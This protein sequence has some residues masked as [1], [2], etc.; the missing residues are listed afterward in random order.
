MKRVEVL[1][2]STYVHI[3]SQNSKCFDITLQAKH[4][5][6]H[7]QLFCVFFVF[8]SVY[9]I[10][11]IKTLQN[12]TNTFFIFVVFDMVSLKNTIIHTGIIELKLVSKLSI[13]NVYIT[14]IKTS[15]T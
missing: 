3:L 11:V 13:E 10:T 1:H 6:R 5:W 9:H 7:N 12:E 8:F 2:T 14:V 15:H 4:R